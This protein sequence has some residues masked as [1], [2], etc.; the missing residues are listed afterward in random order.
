MNNRSLKVRRAIGHIEQLF[1]A[2]N[3]GPIGKFKD[4]ATAVRAI[5]AEFDR[6]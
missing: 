4:K 3:G 2:D 6:K 1:Y 5:L